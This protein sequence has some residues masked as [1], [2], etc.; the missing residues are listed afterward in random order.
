MLSGSLSMPADIIVKK[1]GSS[2]TVFN[3]DIGQKYITF[4]KETAPD[5]ELYRVSRE[6]CFAIKPDEGEMTMLDQYPKDGQQS[7]SVLPAIES[8]GQVLK[9]KVAD[10]NQ[11]LI[12]GYNKSILS[13]EGKEPSKKKIKTTRDVA[14]QYGIAPESVLADENIEV[15]I[16]TYSVAWG[17]D[18]KYERCFT[19]KNKTDRFIYIDLTKSVRHYKENS[20]STFYNTLQETHT[21]GKD[22]GA[23]VNL[24]GVASALGVGGAIG[25]LA[26]GVSIGGKNSNYSTVSYENPQFLTIPPGGVATMPLKKIYSNSTKKVE[27]IAEWLHSNLP[28]IEIEKWSYVELEPKETDYINRFLISYSFSEDLQQRYEICFGI[29][30]RALLATPYGIDWPSSKKIK[31]EGGNGKHL[32][33]VHCHLPKQQ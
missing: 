30:A 8:D 31:V 22:A 16:N 20:G 33:D 26:S 23:G 13:Y 5:S 6:E 1:D 10:N 19:V 24:G 12:D 18:I 14:I 28:S 32:I 7:V 2:L 15:D 25:S 3:V 4:T 27:E 9:A 21:S 17:G 29:Y 11:V